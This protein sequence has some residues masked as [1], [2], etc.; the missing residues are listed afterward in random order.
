MG[1]KAFLP[2]RHSPLPFFPAWP[3]SCGNPPCAGITATLHHTCFHFLPKSFYCVSTGTGRPQ[4]MW[5]SKDNFLELFCPS[6]SFRQVCL[7]SDSAMCSSWLPSGLFSRPHPP[8][9]YRSGGLHSHLSCGFR[10]PNSIIMTSWQ[11]LCRSWSS[12]Q[13]PMSFPK[14]NF[15]C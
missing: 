5:R 10:R 7:V 8:P 13:P 11:A 9:G 4:L 2:I 6:I 14:G 12:W 1:Q 3:W 15:P